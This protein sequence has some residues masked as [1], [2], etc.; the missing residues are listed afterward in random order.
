[1]PSARLIAPLATAVALACAGAAVATG[2]DRAH[3]AGSSPDQTTTRLR[4]SSDGKRVAKMRIFYPLV[5]DGQRAGRTYTDI[6]PIPLR[7]DRSF[8]GR[9]HYYGSTNHWLNKFVVKG[10][11]SSRRARGTFSLRE[12]GTNPVTGASVH[13]QSGSTGSVVWTASRVRR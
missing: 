11:L 9:G 8:T 12:S 2:L 1:M 5:C 3:Y 6:Y 10:K 7:R 4:L 13:C